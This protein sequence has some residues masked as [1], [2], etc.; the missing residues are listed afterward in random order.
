MDIYCHW[1]PGREGLVWKKLWAVKKRYQIVYE[2]CEILLY[3]EVTSVG[4][5]VDLYNSIK[6][7]YIFWIDDA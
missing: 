2:I 4:R 1:S 7:A 6:R 3:K 5:V